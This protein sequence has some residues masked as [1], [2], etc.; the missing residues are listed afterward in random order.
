MMGGN[1]TFEID[2]PV[3]STTKECDPALF[4]FWDKYG[5]WSPLDSF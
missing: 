1:S 5:E 3:N 4:G 2:S